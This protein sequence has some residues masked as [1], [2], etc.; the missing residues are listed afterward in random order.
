MTTSGELTVFLGREL[1]SKGSE[2]K[3]VPLFPKTSADASR[4][5]TVAEYGTSC[6]YKRVYGKKFPQL[7]SD[8]K[9]DH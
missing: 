8:S 7:L 6:L 2:T 3:C 9:K 4:K 1:F 5:L